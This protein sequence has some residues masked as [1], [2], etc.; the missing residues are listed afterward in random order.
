MLRFR[1]G[2]AALCLLA[3]VSGPAAGDDAKGK[4]QVVVVGTYHFSN[5]GLD[6]H[7]IKADDVLKPERQREIEEIVRSL[8]AYKPTFVGVEWPAA[9]VDERYPKYL[10]GTLAPSRNEVVQLGFRL[11]KQSGLDKMHGLDVPGDF[12][13]EPVKK[14]AQA[15]GRMGMIDELMVAGERETAKVTAMQENGTIGDILRYM[16]Q[17]ESIAA[18]HSAYPTMLLFGRG[19]EQPGVALLS[20]WYTR[21]LAICARLLQALKPDDRAVVFF[22]Q[23]HVYLISQ[24]LDE[25]PGVERVDALAWLP[26]K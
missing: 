25:A 11:A 21:N 20:S 22:G 3:L 18:N 4:A 10:D 6:Q 14:W 1:T 17:P 13:F 26:K 23:G 16:N 5:P 8:G 7:N 9:I 15:N 2:T 19:E 24:C 12:P